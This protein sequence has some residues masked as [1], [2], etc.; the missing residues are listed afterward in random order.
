MTAVQPLLPYEV[1]R[2]RLTLAG[3]ARAGDWIFASGLMPTRFGSAARPLSGEP[4]WTIQFRSVWERAQAVLE[5]GGTDL[6]HAVRCDQFLP[7]WRAMPFFHE[8]RRHACGQHIPPS[9]SV[10]EAG[11]LLPEAAVT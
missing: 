1:N 11:L 3:G 5:A 6:T 2:G 9:T 4:D 10:L 7:D 8:V